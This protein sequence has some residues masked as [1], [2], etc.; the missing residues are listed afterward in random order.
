MGLFVS[1][2]MNG[3]I[4]TVPRCGHLVALSAGYPVI[5]VGV[6]LAVVIFASAPVF[7]VGLFVS[8]TPKKSDGGDYG[9]ATRIEARNEAPR[10][11]RSR[12]KCASLHPG[13]CVWVTS[14]V[15][16]VLFVCC[17]RLC[18]VDRCRMTEWAVSP[19]FEVRVCVAIGHCAEREQLW[20]DGCF[21][22]CDY[23]GRRLH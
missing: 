8:G 2:M 21:A 23:W 13:A 18:W 17:G 1:G 10:G 16:G 12:G 22:S 9:A 15:L 20:M 6:G 3:R 19:A 14:E 4:S 7:A 5:V 11:L